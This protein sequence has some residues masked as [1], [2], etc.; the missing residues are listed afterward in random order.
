MRFLRK[1]FVGLFLLAATLALAI[2][3]LDMVRSAI[4]ARGDNERRGGGGRERV[5][6]VNVVPF[7]PGQ[8]IPELVVFGEVQSRRVLDL[9]SSV[10]GTVIELHPSFADGGT[11]AKGD[12]LVRIDPSDAETAVALIEADLIDAQADL[13]QA[14]DAVTLA[15]DEV[16]AAREQ[17]Q[18][19]EKA[20]QRQRDLLNRGVG[21]AAQLESAE[22]AASS[23]EQ[24]ILS[25][26]QALQTAQGRV[27]TAQ[28]RVTR[29]Q[30]N[31][32][33]AQRN[34]TDTK[35]Y[36]TFDG[37]LSGVTLVEGGTVSGNAQLGQLVDPTMLEVAFR[38]STSQH[39]R[40]LDENGALRPSAVTATLDVLGTS[41]DIQGQLSREAAVVGEGATGRL[42]FAS[43]ANAS[44]VRPGDF[45]TVSIIEA[46]LEWVA[47]LPATA[48]SSTSRVLVVG[49]EDRLEEIEVA[50]V[51][52]QGDDVLVRARGLRD[53]LV[54][55]ERSPLLGAGI[56]VRPLRPEDANKEP[57]APAMVKLDDEERAKM[58]AFIEANNR[59]P[60]EAKKRV[61]SQLKKP[62]VPAQMVERLRGRMGG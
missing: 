23:A 1:S 6:A 53:R 24:S 4:E 51:R 48:V 55:A 7:T 37:V 38:V 31:L 62:E 34:L 39:A 15:E 2:F 20:A 44:G 27:S 59:M 35:I 60:A 45:V 9:R 58:I 52:R 36:A 12:L 41:I 19:R 21:T 47:R 22:L 25:R 49:Q 3:A 33:E 13:K 46:P 32:E 17:S 28:S 8:E 57:E 10:G 61:L 42:L 16:L 40:L 29:I 50:L 5:F 43:L 26:R 18:L 30:I 11:V 54:V 14:I 56:K